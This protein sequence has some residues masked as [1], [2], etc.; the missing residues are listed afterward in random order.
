MGHVFCQ[1]N[2]IFLFLFF[3]FGGVVDPRF[4]R[5]EI[6]CIC[7]LWRACVA[8]H[9]DKSVEWQPRAKRLGRRT[10][11]WVTKIEEFARWKRWDNWEK[12]AT[13]NPALWELSILKVLPFVV[14]K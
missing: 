1:Y 11:T 6:L 7:L 14:A 4:F 8:D 13:R 12:F 9:H 2:F 10:N 3:R 5:V